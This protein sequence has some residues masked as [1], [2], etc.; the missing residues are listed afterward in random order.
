MEARLPGRGIMVQIPLAHPRALSTFYCALEARVIPP[1]VG[2]VI[3]HKRH[4]WARSIYS[5]TAVPE[6]P[7][8][9]QLLSWLIYGI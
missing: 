3:G 7:T 8:R 1:Y 6:R 4:P 9:L 5:G 2:G